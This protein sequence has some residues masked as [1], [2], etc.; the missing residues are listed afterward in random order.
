MGEG[1]PNRRNH[2]CEDRGMQ[3]AYC[4]RSCHLVNMETINEVRYGGDLNNTALKGLF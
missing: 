4:L 3:K 2:M 1:I